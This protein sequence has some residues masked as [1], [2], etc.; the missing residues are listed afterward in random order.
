M[1]YNRLFNRRF[2]PQGAAPGSAANEPPPLR[3]ASLHVMSY[4]A[5]RLE[6]REIQR[7]EDLDEMRPDGQVVWIDVRGRA[8][9]AL[10]DRLGQLFHL[11]HLAAADTI[12]LGQRPKVED[13]GELLFC[14]LHAVEPDALTHYRSEQLSIF[15]GHGFVITFHE[16]AGECVEPV[17]RRLRKGAGRL[18]V[19]GADYLAAMLIDAVVDGYFP[20]LEDFGEIL[21]DLE[22]RVLERPDPGVLKEVYRAKRE[23]MGLRRVVWPLR[24]ALHQL[25]RDRHSA[26]QRDTL[27]YLRDTVDHL[28]QAVDVVETYRELGTGFIDVYLSSVSQR[29]NEVMRVLTIF[30]TLFIPLTFV[31]GV[32]GMNFDHLP[33]LKWRYGYLYFWLLAAVIAGG[34]CLLFRRLGWWQSFTAPPGSDEPDSGDS[35]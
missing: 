32:Y 20:V 27:P 12:N 28:M 21:E 17:R 1:P 8:P 5:T 31:A 16:D 22:K 35:D 19:S 29:T 18:R 9:D 15:F 25:L 10:L 3:P 24:D 23:L 7:L 30:A 33:E 2:T 26:L 11:H 14:V 6:E 4:S 13:Y 34:L